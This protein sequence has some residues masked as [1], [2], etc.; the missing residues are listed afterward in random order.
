VPNEPD[1][2]GGR[3]AAYAELIAAVLD[4][5]S[6]MPTRTFDQTVTQAVADGRLSAELGRELRWLQR[7]S[8]HELVD[9]AERVLPATIVALED[10]LDTDPPSDGQRA[11]AAPPRPVVQPE[12]QPPAAPAPTAHF[13]PAT[14][15]AAATTSPGVPHEPA[16]HTEPAPTDVPSV[17]VDLTA[18]RLL[19]AG[20]RTVEDRP[21]P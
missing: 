9:H 19:V 15:S 2:S 20:L 21:F 11:D 14:D 4:L 3:A 13:E 12:A 7:Q 5:R 1:S 18:R 6:S 10:T 8:L 16:A 17:A